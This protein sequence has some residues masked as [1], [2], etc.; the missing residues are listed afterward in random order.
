MESSTRNLLILYAIVCFFAVAGVALNFISISN[1]KSIEDPEL[2]R[3]MAQ[4]LTRGFYT[5]AF[6]YLVIALT[7]IGAILKRKYSKTLLILLTLL[8]IS[9]FVFGSYI[10][11][12]F[13]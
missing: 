2:T 8:L 6:I 9:T 5:I 4:G 1:L 10:F 3:E 7:S 13:V 12:Y 11:E